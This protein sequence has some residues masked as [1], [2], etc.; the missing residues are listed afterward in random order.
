MNE[1]NKQQTAK[2]HD[3]YTECEALNGQHDTSTI[4]CWNLLNETIAIEIWAAVLISTR[5][6]WICGW[7]KGNEMR[8][9]YLKWAVNLREKTNFITQLWLFLLL[10]SVFMYNRL[11]PFDLLALLLPG[12][13]SIPI[14]NLFPNR[15]L[16]N[17]TKCDKKIA[18]RH[19][20]IEK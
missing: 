19:K 15:L 20:L 3:S 6:H 7:T 8:V 11:V 4:W 5:F 10:V 9:P 18:K 12:F 14:F 17:G 16:W 1:K 13:I 2:R